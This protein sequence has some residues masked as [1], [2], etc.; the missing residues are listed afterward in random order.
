MRDILFRGKQVDNGEWVEGLPYEVDS[1][2]DCI[3][4]KEI[5][6]DTI[7]YTTYKVVPETVGQCI[8]QTDKNGNKVFEGD[9]VKRGLEIYI[10]RWNQEQFKYDFY[11]ANG[12]IQSGLN[13]FAKDYIE[14]IGNVHDT[15]ELLEV[16]E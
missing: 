6:E 2:V 8:Q 7:V 11:T 5:I 4:V 14:V 9:I 16:T 3:R 1:I 15:P 13:I 12:V 10:V